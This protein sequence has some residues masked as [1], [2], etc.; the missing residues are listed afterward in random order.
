MFIVNI[1]SSTLHDYWFSSS[2]CSCEKWSVYFSVL[3]HV[4]SHSVGDGFWHPRATILNGEGAP[5]VWQL[6]PLPQPW[7]SL[8]QRQCFSPLGGFVSS[9]VHLCIFDQYALK[10][11]YFW[12]PIICIFVLPSYYKD[13]GLLPYH[14]HIASLHITPYYCR[15]LG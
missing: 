11:H 12:F 15:T 7:Y 6:L 10:Y 14:V 13:L 5:F 3:Y 1:G 8:H 9:G 2:Q 4:F